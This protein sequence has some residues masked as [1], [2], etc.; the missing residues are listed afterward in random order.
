MDKKWLILVSHVYMILELVIF[1]PY[2]GILSSTYAQIDF[3]KTDGY[4]EFHGEVKE[5][6]TEATDVEYDDYTLVAL[7]L[8]S[9]IEPFVPFAAVCPIFSPMIIWQ[10]NAQMHCAVKWNMDSCWTYSGEWNK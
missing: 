5:W 4:C 2:L 7:I 3:P 9:Y 10:Y 8:D 1:Y 6:I